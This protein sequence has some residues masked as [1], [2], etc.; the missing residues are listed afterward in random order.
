M[1]EHDMIRYHDDKIKKIKYF[2]ARKASGEK[3]VAY[4]SRQKTLR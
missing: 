2:G 3:R 4:I 1:E